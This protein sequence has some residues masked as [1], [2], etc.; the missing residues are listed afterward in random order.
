MRRHLSIITSAVWLGLSLVS[1]INWLF[2]AEFRFPDFRLGKWDTGAEYRVQ[3]MEGEGYILLQKAS[4]IE[5]REGALG[6]INN[7]S[8]EWSFVAGSASFLGAQFINW[9]HTAGHGYPLAI[10]FPGW[11]LAVLFLLLAIV[12]KFALLK[13]RDPPSMRICSQCGY[14]LRATPDQCP[15]CGAAPAG[16]K[17]AT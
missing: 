14:D 3:A 12:C 10:Y 7:Y 16:T 11:W 4:G 17:V 1:V 13:R 6:P 2:L 9:H 5:P 15:E 8:E